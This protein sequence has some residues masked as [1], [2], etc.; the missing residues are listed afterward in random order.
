MY[1]EV[2]NNNEFLLIMANRAFKL[3]PFIQEHKKIL[4]YII[5]EKFKGKRHKVTVPD[6]PKYSSLTDD[7][8]LEID[9][10]AVALE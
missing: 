3:L 9:S 1:A 5:S 2:A 6:L 4:S 10:E 7:Q 8:Y